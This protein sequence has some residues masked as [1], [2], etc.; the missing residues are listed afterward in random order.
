MAGL[1]D[2]SES[3]LGVNEVSVNKGKSSCF[4]DAADASSQ[5]PG[6]PQCNSK[7]VWKDGL[8]GEVQRWLCRVCG[9]RFSEVGVSKT[10]KSNGALS[11]D[12]QICVSETKNLV[13]AAETQTVAGGLEALSGNVCRKKARRVGSFW[14]C[15]SCGYKEFA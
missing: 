6:C 15:R 4:G 1:A 2:A 3:I 9:F 5:F 14:V 12:C 8:R 7:K 13:L 11:S 10:L